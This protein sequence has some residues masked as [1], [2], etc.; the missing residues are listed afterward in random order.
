MKKQLSY[1]AVMMILG[2]MAAC[3]AIAILGAIAVPVF[4]SH[5]L[6]IAEHNDFQRM[7]A[8]F[9]PA[10][11]GPEPLLVLALLIVLSAIILLLAALNPNFRFEKMLDPKAAGKGAV[12]LL[13]ALGLVVFSVFLE[14]IGAGGI[15]LRFFYLPLAS[16]ALWLLA[17]ENGWAG[18]LSTWKSQ[19][20]TGDPDRPAIILMGVL[21][22]LT[23]GLLTLFSKQLFQKFFIV[24]SEV[25]DGTGETSYVGFVWFLVGISVLIAL[26][27]G[28]LMG[29]AFS[30]APAV[31]DREQRSRMLMAPGILTLTLFVI[32]AGGYLYAVGNYDLG[33]DSLV[34]AAG[35]PEEA[36]EILTVVNLSA[37]GSS[38][39]AAWPWPLEVKT[40]S[41]A[42]SDTVTVS[43]QVMTELDRFLEENRGNSVFQYNA[44]D[45]R[46][47]SAFAMFELE[48]VERRIADFAGD[49]LIARM[50]QLY[51]LRNL[52]TTEGNREILLSYADEDKWN[53]PGRPALSLS[54]AFEHFAMQEEARYWFDR[55]LDSGQEPEEFSPSE[56]AVL[57]GGTIA[58][59]LT[60]QETEP[61]NVKIGLMN[62][63]RVLAGELTLM[64]LQMDLLTAT[65][66][67]EDGA[68]TFTDL[69]RGEYRLLALLPT[70]VDPSSIVIEDDTGLIK[71]D[72]E[73]PVVEVGTIA[74]SY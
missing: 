1:M 30:L 53:I 27:G 70:Q 17:G 10:A 11:E 63:R 18:D 50:T 40:W 55:A 33:A 4:D 43:S 36:P 45:L 16:G 71:L 12:I 42:Y 35:L 21:W 14:E 29:L 73:N 19:T 23:A 64:D 54:R 28:I 47:K 58:G 48:G 9:G 46:L 3:L 44:M 13:A 32:A 56:G 57:T 74:I 72:M 60:V 62:A 20:S 51:R 31:M 67:R 15:L 6:S 25:L 65:T 34:E 66:P 24:V 2:V 37:S 22:G 69:G 5:L 59:N 52:P 68:F 8:I 39:Q 38:D 7:H 26:A 49:L 61:G 41:M